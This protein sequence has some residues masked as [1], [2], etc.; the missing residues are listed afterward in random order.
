MNPFE[1]V[2]SL[3]KASISHT[4]YIRGF[5]YAEG[6]FGPMDFTFD[7]DNQNASGGAILRQPTIG[8]PPPF[9]RPSSYAVLNPAV[10]FGRQFP[11]GVDSLTEEQEKDLMYHTGAV[12]LHEATH[13]AVHW[14]EPR[15]QRLYGQQPQGHE[16]PA[17]TAEHEADTK[18]PNFMAKLR[19]LYSHPSVNEE[20]YVENP[21]TPRMQKIKEIATAIKGVKDP[22]EQAQIMGN[23]A[24]MNAKSEMER[25][26][27]IDE[28]RA[29]IDRLED[30]IDWDNANKEEIQAVFT[31]TNRLSE[32]ASQL[33]RWYD[34]ILRGV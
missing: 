22:Y 1:T 23:R 12:G 34:D 6:G 9:D 32:K 26:G 10:H 27:K 17:Y 30:S 7:E 16:Y 13:Q 29:E 3:L 2:W 19:A 31:Y 5:P 14:A 28:L 24:R 20:G 8:G 18:H 4:E 11:D 21:Q 33:R 15:L 25:L